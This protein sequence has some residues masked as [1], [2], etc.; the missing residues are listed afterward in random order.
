[1][2]FGQRLQDLRRKAG[3][4]QDT[5]A[6][7]LEVSRQAVSKWERDEA[8]PET[9]KVIRIAQL[10]DVSLDTLLVGRAPEPERPA[11][12]RDPYPQPRPSGISGDRVTRFIRRHGYKAGYALMTG[13][14]VLCV[15]SILLYLVW[16]AIGSAFFGGIQDSMGGLGGYGIQFEGDVPPEVQDALRDE[17]QGG[18]IGGFWN[19]ATNQMG[20][21][22]NS[23][24]KA[25]AML[26]LIPMVPG[27]ILILAGAV[28]VVKGKKLAAEAQD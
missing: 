25:Q 6:E 15:L 22:V 20:S 3:M 24:L 18:L 5:L 16:P 23:A 9:E 13:G 27:G 11:Q 4:S 26:F 14:A 19:Q 17:L 7:K 21:M 12:P 28:I 10:F 8:M 2:T 1:M